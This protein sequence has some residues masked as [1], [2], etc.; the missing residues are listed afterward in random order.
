MNAAARLVCHS[1]RLTSVSGLLHD[2]N[3]WLPMP[4]LV[5]YKLCLLVFKAVYGTAPNYLSE[6][7]QSNAEDTARSRLHSTAHCDFQVPRSKSNFGDR[8]FAVDGPASWNRL[9]ATI[10]SSDTAEFQETIESYLLLMDHFFSSVHLE[11]T[12]QN[13]TPCQR[14]RN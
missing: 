2:R 12:P 8:A 13:L 9:P 11:C 5:R 3:H 4:E 1:G 7:C 10:R 6:L 14:L